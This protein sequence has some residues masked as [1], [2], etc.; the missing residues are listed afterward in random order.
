VEGVPLLPNPNSPH[1]NTSLGIHRGAP[2]KN[3]LFDHHSPVIGIQHEGVEQTFG[4]SIALHPTL[5]LLTWTPRVVSIA[6]L[7]TTP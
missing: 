3:L 4:I 5:P 1:L 6:V 2:Q 7:H